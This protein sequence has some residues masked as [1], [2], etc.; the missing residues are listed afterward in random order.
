MSG[1]RASCWAYA[2]SWAGLLLR[3]G[4]A[5]CWAAARWRAEKLLLLF[6]FLFLFSFSSPLVDFI[7]GLKFE[8][9]IGVTYSL[10]F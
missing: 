7:F 9:Q 5:A 4:G 3:A 2:S 1:V 6:F 10:G 8:F